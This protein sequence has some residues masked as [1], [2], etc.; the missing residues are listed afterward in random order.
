MTTHYLK[1]EL[2]NREGVEYTSTDFSKLIFYS[3]VVDNIW[4]MDD[5]LPDLNE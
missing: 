1:I 4:D 2:A 3:I 5:A